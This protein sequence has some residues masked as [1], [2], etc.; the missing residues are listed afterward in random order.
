MHIN[1]GSEVSKIHLGEGFVAQDARIIDQY[2]H[3][4]PCFDCVGHHGLDLSVIRDIGAVRHRCATL[5]FDLR[6]HIPGSSAPLTHPVET[7][8]EI[9]YDDPRTAACKFER[10]TFT[11]TITGTGNDHYLIVKSYAHW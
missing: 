4:T 11:E 6:N 9:V 1:D 7:P 10:M 8:A 3:A 2:V 5:G